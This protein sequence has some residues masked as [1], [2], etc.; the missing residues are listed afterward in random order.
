MCYGDLDPKY[1]MREMEER[2]GGRVPARSAEAAGGWPLAA[3][4]ARVPGWI[5]GVWR[6][7]SPL[8]PLRGRRG[9]ARVGGAGASPLPRERGRGRGFPAKGAQP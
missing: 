3:A 7:A 2:L 1:L 8:A 4:L 5:A 9:E 6:A